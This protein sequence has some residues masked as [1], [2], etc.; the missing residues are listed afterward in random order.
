M[1]YEMLMNDDNQF[2]EP[3][4][5][6]ISVFGYLCNKLKPWLEPVL[7][8]RIW[9]YK[10][11]ITVPKHVAMTLFKLGSDAEYQIIVNV[12][13]VAKSTILKSISNVINA[14]IDVFENEV[15]NVPDEHQ[16]KK[17]SNRF[18]I[19]SEIPFICG[20]KDGIGYIYQ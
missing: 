18:Q 20:S 4:R 13:G 12:Y 10:K 6:S 5:V 3:F 1:L 16:C 2:K 7:N 19:I 17:I 8:N 14:I 15:I 11:T 9:S